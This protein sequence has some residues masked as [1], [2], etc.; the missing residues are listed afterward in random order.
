MVDD[1]NKEFSLLALKITNA[2]EEDLVEDYIE[3]L[4]PGIMYETD[5]IELA[6][7]DEAME[8]ALDSEIWLKQASSR[9]QSRWSR[10]P[11]S[12]PSPVI[13]PTGPAPME[14]CDVGVRP[15]RRL[16]PRHPLI[17]Q[18]VWE[19]R[20][21][22][23]RCLLC[24]EN[25]DMMAGCRNGP[26]LPPHM[27]TI[28]T[29]SQSRSPWPP[30]ASPG[31]APFVP[32]FGATPGYPWPPPPY[33]SLPF[34]YPINQPS[35][36]QPAC[37]AGLRRIAGVRT[38]RSRNENDETVVKPDLTVCYEVE[39]DKRQRTD[40]ELSEEED[41]E[42]D[43][44]ETGFV[45]HGTVAGAPVRVLYDIGADDIF[46][47]SKFAHLRQL[48]I[49]RFGTPMR[50]RVAV[51]EPRGREAK[52]AIRKGA[53]CHIVR[54][55]T[56]HWPAGEAEQECFVYAIE[57]EVTFLGLKISRTGMRPKQSKT[58]QSHKRLQQKGQ[59]RWSLRGLSASTG[60]PNQ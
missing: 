56:A 10:G 43:S 46:I 60:C 4:P 38:I 31:F 21:R 54:M 53:V 18:M 8:K 6:T 55:E 25:T 52:R 51:K 33:P 24:G 41:D 7:L 22:L 16:L 2:N 36:H 12:D 49:R 17:P 58:D 29:T 11:P 15:S 45:Y 23:N 50:C 47:D 32:G 13:D 59:P 28:Q 35:G 48:H 5:R 3:G 57:T 20:G 1:Y 37:K 14:L 42:D 34:P 40:E 44:F 9:S 39:E 30:R 19:S 26:Q 27:R